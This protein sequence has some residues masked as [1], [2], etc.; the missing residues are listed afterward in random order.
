[1]ALTL[2]MATRVTKTIGFLAILNEMMRSA[3]YA[4]WPEY[5]VNTTYETTYS[6]VHKSDPP[7][8]PVTPQVEVTGFIPA[9]HPRTGLGLARHRQKRGPS[10][11]IQ[12]R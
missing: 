9:R 1:M 7:L 12:D 5:A 3:R 8:L 6:D 4:Y 2:I 10:P 11:L